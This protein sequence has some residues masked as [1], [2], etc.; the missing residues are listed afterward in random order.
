MTQ[1]YTYLFCQI[2]KKYIF[3]V[4]QNFI[5]RF[6]VCH[7]MEKVENCCSR[8]LD[9]SLTFSGPWSLPLNVRGVTQTSLPVFKTVCLLPF[10]SLRAFIETNQNR[11][12]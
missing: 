2:G 5:S 11:E 6:I 9:E 10:R 1:N 8:S 7:E 12:Q 3:G 4:P